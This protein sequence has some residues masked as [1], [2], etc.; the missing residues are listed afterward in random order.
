YYVKSYNIDPNDTVTSTSRYIVKKSK[1]LR[2]KEYYFRLRNSQIYFFRNYNINPRYLYK[3][4][5]LKNSIRYDWNKNYE[6]FYLSLTTDEKTYLLV[7][8]F[9]LLKNKREE[10]YNFVLGINRR[11]YRYK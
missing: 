9:I 3:V 8:V 7:F 10:Y 4:E 1:I 11:A 2:K 6:R 5:Y